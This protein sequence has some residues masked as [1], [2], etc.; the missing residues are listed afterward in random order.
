[1]KIFKRLALMT[2]M[3]TMIH[4]TT[5][6]EPITLR[7]IVEGFYGAPW[8]FKARTE[9]MS[10]CRKNNLNAYIYAPKDDAFHRD[11]WREPYPENN[12]ED[13]KILVDTAK[14]NNVRF[15]FAISPG[16]D[17]NYKGKK[18]DED[19][20]LMLQKIESVY[21]I[22]V[23]DFA[24]FFDDIKDDDGKNQAE[25]LN[26]LQDAL[27]KRHTDI[28]HLITVPKEYFYDDMVKGG[29][30]KAKP[31][32]EDFAKNLDRR[33]L[34]L[35]TGKGV[36]CEGI[37]DSELAAANKLYGRDL[38]VWWNYPVNDYPLTENG[39]REVKLAL[40]A[41]EN[42]PKTNL[43]AIFFNPMSRPELSKIALAT[44]ANY[45]NAPAMYDPEK[46]WN[47]AID[48]QFGEVAPAMKVFA[49]HSR[50]LQNSWANV[51]KADAPEFTTA[52]YL[53]IN[54][55]K[56]GKSADFTAIDE[57]IDEM[58]KSADI[59]LKNMKREPLRECQFQLEQFRRLA[60]ADRLAVQSLKDKKLHPRLRMLREE[61]SLHESEAVLSEN[62][63]RKF[64]DD[65]IELFPETKKKK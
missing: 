28:A 1:M 61:I 3:M 54:A 32:T 15:I 50:H 30:G 56:K 10:F 24:V 11:K 62:V 26:K 49:S 16:L 57:I 35:Y 43:P 19:F 6:A 23:R 36:V 33:I 60:R 34:V 4:G 8:T 45:A 2:L 39:N 18:G 63:A 55:Y 51:G 46:A 44:G 7:G 31:Y 41:I 20:D 27:L 25:F 21:K 9:M 13:M 47:T 64:I 42:L 58:E 17:L 53:V 37:S 65:V 40:G 48:N 52:A 12:L 5:F 38:G 14:K 29:K 59:L 22:G